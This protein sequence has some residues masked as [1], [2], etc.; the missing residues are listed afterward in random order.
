[1]AYHARTTEHAGPKKGNGAFWGPKQIAKHGSNRKRRGDARREIKTSIAEL[2]QGEAA[3]TQAGVP[4]T[5]RTATTGREG[6]QPARAVGRSRGPPRRGPR[7]A[8]CYS[9][10]ATDAGGAAEVRGAQSTLDR[11]IARPDLIPPARLSPSVPRHDLH[12]GAIRHGADAAGPVRLRERHTTQGRI[13]TDDHRVAA[14]RERCTLRAEGPEGG[15]RRGGHTY[16]RPAP[17]G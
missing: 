17:H 16:R 12:F 8:R 15:A 7:R 4:I 2:V 10:S 6:R 3:N 11:A 5:T 9:A 13:R 1:M 14:D